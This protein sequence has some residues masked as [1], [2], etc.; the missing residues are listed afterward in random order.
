M[1]SL[2]KI[3]LFI[4]SISF[5]LAYNQEKKE[6][7]ASYTE[8]KIVL[9]GIQNEISW[10][11]KKMVRDSFF[12][13]IPVPESKGSSMNEFKIIYDKKNIYVFAKLFSEAKKISVPSL[14]RDW[15]IRGS[16]GFLILF[17][18]YKDG[19]NAFWFES[20]SVG[21]KKDALVSNGGQRFESDVDFSWDIKWDVKSSPGEG[22]YNLEF[23]IPFSSLKFP[24]GSTKWKV[25]FFRADNYNSEFNSWTLIPKG[26]TPVNLA[27]YGDLIFDKPLGSSKSPLILIPY[28]NGLISKNYEKNYN[29]SDLALGV[30][31][32]I[33]IGNG[34]DLDLT[35]NPDF[36]QVEV[37]GQIIN[38][39]RFEVNLPEK[40]QFFIQNSDLFSSFG[41]SRDS[42]TFFSRRIGVAKDDDGNTIENRI[43][44]GVRLS[45]KLNNNLRLG[46]LNMQTEEDAKNNISANNNMVFALQQK[47]FSRSNISLLFINREKTGNSNLNNDQ[48]KFNRIAG[49]D[50]NLRSKDS[51]WSGKL[52]YHNSLNEQ[53]KNNS[54]STGLNLFLNTRKH[55]LY[56]KSIRLGEGFQSDLGFIRRNGIFKQFLRYER[57]FWIESD[58]ITNISITNNIRYIT[59]PNENSLITDRDYSIGFEINYKNLSNFEFEFSFPYTYL[60]NEFNVTRKD[61]AVPIPI[62]GYNYPNY[63]ISF[64]N[65]F[66]KKFSYFLAVDGGQFFNGSKKSFQTKLAYRIEPFIQASMN[67]SYDKIK[68]PKPYDSADLWLIGPKIT[69][70]FNKQLFWYNLIQYSSVAENFGV[71]SRLK[72]RFAPLSDLYLVYNDNYFASNIFAPK[73][74]SLTFKLSYWFNL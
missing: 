47:V 72:W 14:E 8:E 71:N 68:L 15:K 63:G 62:G 23:K 29:Y 65:S 12:Q 26:Q 20:N 45:G 41:D 57:R 3:F 74:R 30:D 37:D 56:I 7:F 42:R 43:L 61:G 22:Y 11:K 6:I 69:F 52:F 50:Y 36:S 55:G 2:N 39:T 46:F 10:K 28:S 31:A 18:T 21:V 25:Q 67:L 1:N 19:S 48:E 24:E 64:R 38:L 60:D 51:K 5:F 58:R 32:K 9:D 40:R 17:D 70:T 33:S 44:A 16:D 54:Y 73:I 49:I 13:F 66:F 4:L 35:L 53:K 27:F 59:K 34:M